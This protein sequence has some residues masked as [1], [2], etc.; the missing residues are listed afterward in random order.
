MDKGFVKA[1]FNGKAAIMHIINFEG[2]MYSLTL[3]AANKLQDLG[4]NAAVEIEVNEDFKAFSGATKPANVAIVS[5]QEQVKKV[6][7]YMLAQEFTHFPTGVEEVVALRF[8][9]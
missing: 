1:T 5:N 3:K 9:I 4:N 2:T 8:D 7:D 6:F